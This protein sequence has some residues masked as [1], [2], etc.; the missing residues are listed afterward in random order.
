MCG[1]FAYIWNIDR[2]YTNQ[3]N[4]KFITRQFNKGVSRGPE[5]SFKFLK[6]WYSTSVF[7]GFHRLAIN[8]LNQISNQPICID[9]IY[10]IC[11]GEIYNHASF[12][13][14]RVGQSDCEVIIHLYKLYG[15]DYLFD[16]L[17]GVFAFVLYDANI[18]KVY[19]ARDPYGVRPMYYYN[20]DVFV[21][22]SEIKQLDKFGISMQHFEPGT[23]MEITLDKKFLPSITKTKKYTHFGFSKMIF[24]NIYDIY[25]IVYQQLYSAVK[26]RVVGTTERPI[27]CLL[28]GGLDSSTI[29]ALVNSFMPTGKLETYSIGLEGSTDLVYAEKVATYLGTKHTSIILTEDDFFNTIPIV[30]N[31]LETYDTT[32]VRA[33]VGNYL[34]GKYILEHSD[35]KVI[36]NGDGADE[37]MGGYLYFNNAPNPIEFDKEC[38]RLLNNIHYFDGLRSDRCIST[39]GLEPRTPFLDRDFVQSYLSIPNEL[40]C[41]K[42]QGVCEKFIIRNAI[43][44]MNKDLLPKEVLFRTKEAFSDGVSSLERSWY[45]IIQEKIHGKFLNKSEF[46]YLNPT[47]MEQ[48]YYR[49]IFESLYPGCGEICPYFWMP[50]WTNAT[51]PSARTLTNYKV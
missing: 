10:L 29:T 31:A 28:S 27:A 26:K 35:A 19:V 4:E 30:I 47:S 45:Q 5:G 34:I 36:F 23:Y 3:I 9:N 25:G 48:R 39:H 51:D 1:I 50:K 11:N 14:P 32:T 20:K 42:T 21:F 15:I 49:T 2:S 22:A 18:Q 24:N 43:D 16:L 40:R 41:H 38:K 46:V 17:D 7:L 37:L 12:K 44:F 8:G 33:S 6:E 13:I